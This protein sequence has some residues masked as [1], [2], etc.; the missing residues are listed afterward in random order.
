MIV[1]ER[2][3]AIREMKQM[4]QGDIEKK[5]GSPTLLFVSCREWSHRSGNRDTGK[6]CASHAWI[7]S[8][9]SCSTKQKARRRK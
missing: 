7:S 3:R 2:L 6:N 8:C 1:G 4:S 5:T 9:I